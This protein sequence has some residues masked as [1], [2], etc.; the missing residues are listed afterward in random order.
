MGEVRG[1]ETFFLIY[2][3]NCFILYLQVEKARNEIKEGVS[4]IEDI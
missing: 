1:E 3:F 2:F 4:N